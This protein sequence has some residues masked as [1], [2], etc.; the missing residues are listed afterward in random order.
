MAPLFSVLWLEKEGDVQNSHRERS[1]E[2]SVVIVAG[3]AGTRAGL[4]RTMQSVRAQASFEHMEVVIVDCSAPG[5]AGLKGSDHPNVRTI[6]MPRDSTTMAQARAEG[7]R[8]A[9]APIVAFLDEHSFAMAG[10]AQAL[11]EAHKG[12]WAGVGGEIYNLSSAVGVADPIYLMGHGRWI[13]PAQ[14]GEVELLPSHDTCYKK[15]ILLGYGD[16]LP[17]LL[18]AEPVLMWKLRKD[19]YRLFLEPDVKSMHGYT[20]NPLTLVA[21]YAWSRC[22]G[23][24]R[25]SVFD[26]PWSKRVMHALATPIIPWARSFNLFKML[27]K[28]RPASLW[29]FFTGLPFILLAQ[30]G[31]VI[32]EAVGMLFG[33]GNTEILFTQT[34]LRGLRI[35]PELPD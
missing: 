29:V 34:H 3:D 17:F 2:L 9:K 18:M 35:F 12:P 6:K 16:E 10:W 14:R 1:V 21:F 33:K 26:W 25:A 32:G 20:V 31:A 23:H 30:Y 11:I 8:Q 27:L 4:E 7:V 24:A 28:K 5:T 15:E 22:F 19:G 13:P